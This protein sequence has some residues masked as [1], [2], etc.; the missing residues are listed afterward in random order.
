MQTLELNEIRSLIPFINPEG[1]HIEQEA[2]QLGDRLTIQLRLDSKCVGRLERYGDDVLERDMPDY[3]RE[4]SPEILEKAARDYRQNRV[5]RARPNLAV[6]VSRVTETDMLKRFG[7]HNGTYTHFAWETCAYDSTDIFA[8]RHLLGHKLKLNATMRL[9]KLGAVYVPDK[10]YCVAMYQ[11][12]PREYL[13]SLRQMAMSSNKMSD[14]L[15]EYFT[16]GDGHHSAR[17][18]EQETEHVQMLWNL[19]EELRPD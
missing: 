18:L 8:Q 2:L 7:M 5:P 10:G 13:T 15:N 1:K 4:P 11:L 19:Y 3:W 9:D 12:I 6:V 14:R 16:G 17:A